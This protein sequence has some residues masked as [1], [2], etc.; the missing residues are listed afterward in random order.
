[1]S[2]MWLI[3]T[4]GPELVNF[5]APTVKL[6]PPEVSDRVLGGRGC[7]GAVLCFVTDWRR[8]RLKN[9]SRGLASVFSEGDNPSAIA[10]EYLSEK[11]RETV[12]AEGLF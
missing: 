1:M 4:S 7:V 6:S 10:P 11:N 2:T 12:V 5:W 8:K 9:D 3:V